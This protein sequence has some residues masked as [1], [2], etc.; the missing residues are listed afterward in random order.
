[1]AGKTAVVTTP[2]TY[3]GLTSKVNP[4]ANGKW[5]ESKRNIVNELNKIMENLDLKKESDMESEG[6]SYNISNYSEEDFIAHYGDVSFSS[7][8]EWMSGLEMHDD[9]QTIFFSHSNHCT[10]NLH[11]V[12][13]IINNTTDKSTAIITQLS[14]HKI[15]SEGPIIWLEGETKEIIAAREK[16]HLTAAKW[17]TIKAAI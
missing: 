5:A 1:L 4:L 12:Y 13:I 17:E 3:V 6:N 14:I 9:E 10:S 16:V 7:E 15:F 8:D 11:Q 2:E